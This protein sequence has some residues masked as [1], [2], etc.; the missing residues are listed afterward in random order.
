MTEKSVYVKSS[1]LSPLK[2]NYM[3]RGYKEETAE[4]Y[5]DRMRTANTVEH[6]KEYYQAAQLS[7]GEWMTPF[8]MRYL[9]EVYN[10]KM[11]YLTTIPKGSKDLTTGDIRKIQKATSKKELVIILQE[12][13]VRGMKTSERAYLKTLADKRIVELTKQATVKELPQVKLVDLESSELNATYGILTKEEANKRKK[14]AKEERRAECRKN[15]RERKRK[16]SRQNCII[17]GE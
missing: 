2:P 3:W 16:D 1:E 7:V 12:V 13:Y 14:R 5:A 17:P 15:R 11:R 9:Q 8:I 4:E 6:L 10:E